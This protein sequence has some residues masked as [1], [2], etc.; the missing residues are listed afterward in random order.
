MAVSICITVLG[1]SIMKILEYKNLGPLFSSDR[2]S[3]ESSVLLWCKSI[4]QYELG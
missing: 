2:A 1:S 3:A 4:E